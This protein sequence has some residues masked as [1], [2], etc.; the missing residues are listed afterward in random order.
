[1]VAKSQKNALVYYDFNRIYSLLKTQRS[2]KLSSIFYVT[3]LP[4]CLED[5]SS[6]DIMM[7][8]DF[9]RVLKRMKS[10]NTQTSTSFSPFYLFYII[11]LHSYFLLYS[12]SSLIIVCNLWSWC[13]SEDFK[14]RKFLW[15]IMQLQQASFGT[16]I[17]ELLNK[18]QRNIAQLF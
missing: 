16:D 8:L 18:T 10:I 14:N 17:S 4:S 2:W 6:L 9:S 11:L 15:N 1:M 13:V 5:L 12:F 3:A 7:I